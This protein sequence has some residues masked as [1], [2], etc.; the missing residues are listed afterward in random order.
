MPTTAFNVIYQLTHLYHHFF[1]EG[2]GMRQIIDYYYVVCDFYKV[3]QNSSKITPSLFTI[4]EGST[5]YPDPLTLREREETA[6]LGARN[7]YALR[8]ADHQRSRQIVRDGTA[9]V[10]VG[11]RVLFPVLQVLLLLLSVLL[12]L[13]ILLPLL[14]WMWYREN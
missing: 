12:S 11:I 5:S 3:Y 6:L 2:I 8:M 13:Q 14:L 7:R 10:L 4:K 9:G 1:D